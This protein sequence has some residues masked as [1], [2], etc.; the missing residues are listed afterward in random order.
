MLAR[1]R[2]DDYWAG[3]EKY[4]LFIFLIS[5]KSS[6]VCIEIYVVDNVRKNCFVK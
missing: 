4:V 5:I 2:F 3:N 6:S 1:E